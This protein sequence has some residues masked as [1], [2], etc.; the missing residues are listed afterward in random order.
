MNATLKNVEVPL[1]T[2]RASLGG[3]VVRFDS[4]T[5]HSAEEVEVWVIANMG[6]DAGFPEYFYDIISMLEV[7]QD[8]SKT[9]DDLL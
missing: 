3:E 4:E 1:K 2:I 8:S 6:K 5:F 7:L 9:S